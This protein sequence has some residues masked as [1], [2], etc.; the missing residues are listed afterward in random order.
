M[1]DGE[2]CKE[3][4]RAYAVVGI[5]LLELQTVHPK[6]WVGP[7]EAIY[8]VVIFHAAGTVQVLSG[9][10]YLTVELSL[11]GLNSPLHR[12]QNRMSSFL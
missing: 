8:M 11:Q 6:A 7:N 3:E 9:G 12:N 10:S 2:E 4:A 1:W 5:R